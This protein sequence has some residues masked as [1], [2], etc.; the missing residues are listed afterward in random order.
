MEGV[1]SSNDIL[2]LSKFSVSKNKI[3]MFILLG[4]VLL[5][6]NLLQ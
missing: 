5:L 1:A 4:T 6:G 3:V 2:I